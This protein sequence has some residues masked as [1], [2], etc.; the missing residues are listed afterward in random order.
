MIKVIKKTGVTVDFDTNKIISAVSKSAERVMVKLTE[1]DYKS[2]I[3]EVKKLIAEYGLNEVSVSK[4][5][6]IV[7]KALTKVNKEV[8]NSYIE[9]RNYKK[10]FVN[11]LDE[12][13]S[14]SQKIMYLGDKDN[15][16]TDSALVTTKRSLIYGELNKEL[17]N[18]FFLTKEEQQA[19]KDGF[20]YIHDKSARRDTMN[21]FAGE[22]KFISNKGLKSF[23]EFKDGDVI[24]VPTHTGE[25]KTAVVHNYGEQELQKVIFRRGS[26]SLKEVYCTP[27]HRWLLK[28]GSETSNLKVGDK[29]ISAPIISDF[30]W[31]ELTKKQKTLWVY[32]FCIGDGHTRQNSKNSYYTHIRLCG[33]KARYKEFFED[34]GFTV[35]KPDCYNGDFSVYVPNFKKDEYDP[36]KLSYD[37]VKYFINGLLSA[38]GNRNL[39]YN[40]KSPYRGIQVTG[41][42]N[43]YIEDLLN[44]AG[45]YVTNKTNKT[46]EITNYGKRTNITYH[47]GFHSNQGFRTWKVENIIPTNRKE[48]VWCL[49]VED[50][51]SFILE[52]GIP[53]GN[54]CLYNTKEVMNGG[55]EMGNLWYNEPNTVDVACDVLGDIIMSAASSQY[56]ER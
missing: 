24:K 11:M 56:G 41:D 31:D 21:C 10:D 48:T 36:T 49:E 19:C 34:A 43:S 40:C 51:H 22:T 54:C 4:M 50:N 2:I 25:W 46:N 1:D 55:F 6:D 18:K 26:K 28:N 12:V 20:I 5:H 27:N 14:K 23:N 7:E 44:I 3:T 32:G 33:D 30:E 13:Y 53:T 9:Y 17:Y 8:A 35:T 52:N 39:D 15:S 16:N 45:Y 47:Y 29:L 42:T 38:D 37:E